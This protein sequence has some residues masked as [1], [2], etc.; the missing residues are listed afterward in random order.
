M[1]FRFSYTH[2]E[3]NKISVKCRDRPV[4]TNIFVYK[5]TVVCA[6][7]LFVII[8]V[9]CF[10]ISLSHCDLIGFSLAG[11]FI[12][13]FISFNL[14]F[15]EVTR[16]I[17]KAA[18]RTA[19]RIYFH[20]AKTMN[21]EIVIRMKIWHWVIIK[22]RWVSNFPRKSFHS[23]CLFFWKINF[24]NIDFIRRLNSFI[25]I[26]VVSAVWSEKTPVRLERICIENCR[27][28]VPNYWTKIKYAS[29]RQGVR[30]TL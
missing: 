17:L 25:I 9:C 23:D 28:I 27:Y 13:S 19:C 8:I 11:I 4:Y 12:Y 5:L 10:S 14:L 6:R 7:C 29:C 21:M 22:T 30:G 20:Q 26:I 24:E 1:R 3:L 16:T 2:F 15:S 18:Q